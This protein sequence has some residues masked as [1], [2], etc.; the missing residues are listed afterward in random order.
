MAPATPLETVPAALSRAGRW[1]VPE[2]VVE[3]S[4]AARTKDSHLRHAVFRGMRLDKL[5]H[6]VI[7]ETPVAPQKRFSVTH[8]E[9]VVDRASGATKG[10]IADYYALAQ[11][12]LLRSLKDRPC[13]LVR[14]PAGLS[15]TV[16]FQKHSEAF[17]VASAN[18]LTAKSSPAGGAVTIVNSL[19]ALE[20]CVQNNAIEF[21]TVN[22]RLP[23]SEKPDRIIFDLDPGDGVAWS[24]IQEGAVLLKALLD[25]L[26]L[27]AFLKTSGGKGLHVVVPITRRY[28]WAQTKAFSGGLVRHLAHVAPTRF[29][30]K[31]GPRNRVG[32]I[33]VDYLRN[34]RGA[35]TAAAWTLRA[36]TA[37]PVSVPI[38]W[39]ELASLP[40]SSFWTLRTVETR[41]R[42]VGDAPWQR[43]GDTLA[44][45]T[46]PARRLNINMHTARNTAETEGETV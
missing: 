26:A 43:Y 42:D 19:A 32:K 3:A 14:A 6:E 27:P 44:S 35:T 28:S 25:E 12:L 20:A 30:A 37:L 23:L 4:F 9:R 18:A 17:N 29:V 36:R 22:S 2:V 10:D 13:A 41:L 46:E 39:D 16:F 7:R 21:H 34:A 15:G 38:A 45:L 5:A 11:A 8:A 33:Y 31:S 40:N 1:V 24:M